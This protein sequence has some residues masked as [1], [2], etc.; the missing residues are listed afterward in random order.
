[1]IKKLIKIF[2]INLTIIF[3]VFVIADYSIYL[4]LKYNYN[5]EHEKFLTV[6]PPFPTYIEKYK[7]G[8]LASSIQYFKKCGKN[9]GFRKFNINDKFKKSPIIIFGCSYAYG[10][11]LNEY[12]TI[13]YKLHQ[14]TKRN[15]FNFGLCACGIQHMLYIINQ[16]FFG[17]LDNQK[18]E[19]AI[20]IYI[21]SHLFRL[22]SKIFP[23]IQNNGINLQYFLDNGKLKLKNY[24]NNI[25]YNTFFLRSLY[26]I[27]DE[28]N[29]KNFTQYK[30]KSFMLANEIFL[31]SKRLLEQ[32]YPGIKFVII[33]FQTINDGPDYELPFF[34]NVLEKEGFIVI[35]TEDLIGRKFEYNTKDMAEDCCHPSESTWDTLLPLI[36]KKL[37]L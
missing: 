13:N 30:Y 22:Q 12:Q 37:K 19:Y 9:L 25:L 3:T 20:Y 31:E 6:L 17:F 26:S 33:N 32:D 15:I 5:K 28:I 35:N 8:Y 10:D 16:K 21:P 18:P 27:I 23:M 24:S 4:K 7:M 34:F 11:L 14:L 2:I 29:R 1:M 36:V